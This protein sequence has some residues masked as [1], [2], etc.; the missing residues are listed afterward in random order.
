MLKREV[1]E[2]VEREGVYIKFYR[3]TTWVL[4]LSVNFVVIVKTR[5]LIGKHD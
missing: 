4:K 5:R 2:R 3:Q 1:S